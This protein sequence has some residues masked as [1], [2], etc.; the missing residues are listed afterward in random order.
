MSC[1][2]PLIIRNKTTHELV[3]VPCGHCYKCL[4]DKREMWSDR[5]KFDIQYAY[6]KGC[7][8]SFCTF[9]YNDDN[10]P[11]NGSLSKDEG[12][13]FLKFLKREIDY[14][15]IKM[16][17][18]KRT[19]SKNNVPHYYF[20]GEYGGKIGRPHYHAIMIG[21]ESET[22]KELS[23]LCWKKGFSTIYPAYTGSIRYVLKYL[24]K[25]S[26]DN[27]KVYIDNNLEPPFALISKG[28][29]K[30]YLL[31]NFKF[32][33]E[34][35]GYLSKG[36]IRP[37]PNYYKR[38]GCIN[39]D[40]SNTVSHLDYKTRAILL[41]GDYDLYQARKSLD[42]ERSFV[43]ELRNNGKPADDSGVKYL[44]SVVTY[45]EKK[46]LEVSK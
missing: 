18:P 36:I 2:T 15:N 39:K 43:N 5:I 14:H 12:K 33:E 21:I 28:I 1:S 34:N 42:I 17:F 24:D 35:N 20:V 27:N 3:S 30:Q 25:Q 37:I 26:K 46:Q 32:I 4:T 16:P 38:L 6:K 13:K 8:S 41:R 29:G 31:E 7:G 44:T 11:L 19:E 22:M 10:Y 23:R 45:L 40:S 9:T